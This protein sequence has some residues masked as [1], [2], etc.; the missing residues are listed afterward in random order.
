MNSTEL[1]SFA[2]AV[3]V[4]KTAEECCLAMKVLLPKLEAI[5]NPCTES[6]VKVINCFMKGCDAAIQQQLLHLQTCEAHQPHQPGG[7]QIQ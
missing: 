1:L 6:L 2:L 3:E 7:G 4:V 5:D